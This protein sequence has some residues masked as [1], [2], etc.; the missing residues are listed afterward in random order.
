M[1][2][3]SHQQPKPTSNPMEGDKPP[4]LK[5]PPELRNRIYGR[6]YEDIL[7]SPKSIRVLALWSASALLQT[8]RQ[9]RGEASAIYYTGNTFRILC[10]RYFEDDNV[11]YKSFRHENDV[12]MQLM[13]WLRSLGRVTRQTIRKIYLDDHYY[14]GTEAGA[15]SIGR[16]RQWLAAAGLKVDGC[17]L[18][19][20]LAIPGDLKLKWFADVDHVEADVDRT[21]A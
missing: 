3:K 12:C 16:Y 10:P 1:N 11:E 8:C 2:L 5:L 7:L 15:A 20:E 9:I 4:L 17:L 13:R 14:H 6:I 21:M 19:V 18:W